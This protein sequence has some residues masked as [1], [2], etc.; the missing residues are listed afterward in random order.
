MH[1]EKRS[2]NELN[3]LPSRRGEEQKL[4][5]EGKYTKLREK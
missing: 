2:C 3:G 4:D 5:T 1:K